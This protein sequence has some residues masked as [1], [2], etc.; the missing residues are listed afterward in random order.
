MILLHA[1]SNAQTRVI[2]YTDQT[3]STV[4]RSVR[5]KTET[6]R[7]LREIRV[8]RITVPDFEKATWTGSPPC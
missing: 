2:L 6:I 4:L 1:G 5:K 8:Q 3:D 7:P